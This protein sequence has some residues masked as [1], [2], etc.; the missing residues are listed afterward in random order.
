MPIRWSE[1]EYKYGVN[2]V[3]ASVIQG[4]AGSIQAQFAV[5]SVMLNRQREEAFA[6]PLGSHG[7]GSIQRVVTPEQFNGFAAPEPQAKNLAILLLSGKLETLGECGNALFYAS[8]NLSNAVWA[9]PRSEQGE[10]FFERAKD[11]GGNFFSD[12]MGAPS[13][14]FVAPEYKGSA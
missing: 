11:V 1:D 10:E 7:F 5:A 6:G 9:N 14:D 3:I 12:R 2:H 13:H 4:E 8:K